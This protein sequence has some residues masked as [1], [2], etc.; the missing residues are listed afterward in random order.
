MSK[1]EKRDWEAVK[2]IFRYLKGNMSYGI[3][4]NTEQCDSSVLGYFDSSYAGDMDDIRPT[5]WYVDN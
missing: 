5:T 1:L 3:I 2:Y 4:F